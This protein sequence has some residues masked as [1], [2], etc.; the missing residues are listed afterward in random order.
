M[1]F[2]RTA[3]AFVLFVP[4]FLPQRANNVSSVCAPPDSKPLFWCFLPQINPLKCST[5]VQLYRTPTYS[6]YPR[7]SW[8]ALVKK[9][10]VGELIYPWRHKST[11]VDWERARNAM[12]EE[13]RRGSGGKGRDWI[14]KEMETD[15]KRQTTFG[16]CF[17]IWW[18]ER[19]REHRLKLPTHRVYSFLL[20]LKVD[21]E[22]L[23]SHGYQKQDNQQIVTSCWCWF[24]SC[25]YKNTRGSSFTL[26][27]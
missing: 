19:H 11:K 22:Y 27:E 17:Y 2:I 20:S 8:A 9:L 13:E 4:Y 1:D 5:V 25:G 6:C 7:D 23:S 18:E 26:S 14:N 3:G 10:F 16:R 12:E 21:D 24:K 15:R